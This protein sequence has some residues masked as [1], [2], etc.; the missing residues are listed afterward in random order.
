MADRRQRSRRVDGAEGERE[1]EIERRERWGSV[2]WRLGLELGAAGPRWATGM[3]RLGVGRP[4]WAGWGS[5][6][7][8]SLIYLAEKKLE[9]REKKERVRE[10]CWTRG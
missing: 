7:S 8:L 5:L 6:S 1:G 4:S 10:R 9:K 2:S 3:G